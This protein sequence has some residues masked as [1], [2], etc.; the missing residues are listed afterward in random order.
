MVE[1]VRITGAVVAFLFVFALTPRAAGQDRQLIVALDA[2]QP[3]P[4]AGMLF[5]DD[6]AIARQQELQRLQFELGL[7][8]ERAA[9]MAE[10]NAEAI[11]VHDQAAAERL[12]L[13]EELWT[14]R[15][16]ELRQQV[17]EARRERDQARRRQGPRWWQRPGLWFAVGLVAGTGAVLA[18]ER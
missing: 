5:P 6:V 16:N 1:R 14:A 2:R 11:R 3:A 10:I 13:R 4:Y 15:A 12:Q 17:E 8:A 18:L 7:A 9:R